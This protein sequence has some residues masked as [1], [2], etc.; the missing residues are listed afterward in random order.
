MPAV[1]GAGT[2]GAGTETYLSEQSLQ[3]GIEPLI[4]ERFAS[5]YF[6]HFRAAPGSRSAGTNSNAD[7]AHHVVDAFEP[8]SK[9]DD[10][11]RHSLRAHDALE[12]GG[13]STFRKRQIETNKQFLSVF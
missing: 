7:L 2:P 3:G 8:D 12:A 1:P 6:F 11:Q 5:Q 9:V 4:V 13:L 10:R